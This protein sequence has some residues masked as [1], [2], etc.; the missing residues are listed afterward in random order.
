MTKDEWKKI[1]LNIKMQRSLVKNGRTPH[2]RDMARHRLYKMLAKVKE[3]KPVAQIEKT[4][5]RY[6][7]I[8]ESKILYFLK[9]QKTKKAI[10]QILN[11]SLSTLYRRLKQMQKR[12]LT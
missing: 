8:P 7:Y 6:I 10:A 12:G 3:Y 2:I 4:H 1:N 11:I 9:T 5:S